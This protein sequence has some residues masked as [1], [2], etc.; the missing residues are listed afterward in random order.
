MKKIELK[1]PGGIL[2]VSFLRN[3]CLLLHSYNIENIYLGNRQ[4][5]ILYP[6]EENY[7]RLLLLLKKNN[8]LLQ[9]SEFNLMLDLN[10]FNEDN[11]LNLNSFE[12]LSKKFL[13]SKLPIQI[14]QK[15][16]EI[17]LLLS[18]INLISDENKNRFYIFINANEQ[19][20]L[21]KNS[22][23]L[24]EVIDFFYQHHFLNW[25]D[26]I[27]NFIKNN[28]NNLETF[29]N[30]QLLK[31]YITH[32]KQLDF[33]N[34]IFK[35]LNHYI[36][37]SSYT[38]NFST[39]ILEKLCIILKKYS[40]GYIFINPYHMLEIPTYP[41][42]NNNLLIQEIHKLFNNQNY[43][44]YHNEYPSFPNNII[45][46]NN[47]EESSKQLVNGLIHLKSIN[48]H[49][50]YIVLNIN[51]STQ[52][53]F[54]G[55][56]DIFIQKSIFRR[57]RR[58]DF[59]INPFIK[60]QIYK[61]LNQN[62]LIKTLNNFIEFIEHYDYLPNKEI[63]NLSI[64]II[65]KERIKQCIECFTVLSRDEQLCPICGSENYQEVLS[66]TEL[67]IKNSLYKNLL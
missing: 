24:N 51:E 60:P 25:E 23:T 55:M 9:D 41:I 15:I 67:I 36:I 46:L 58:Y 34:K 57:G 54:G 37:L 7:E 45:R 13:N 65:E 63:E 31:N 17:S 61:N 56:V 14:L 28:Y 47:F 19:S 66:P 3:L 16:D 33:H 29:S 64:K 18:P 22:F 12:E 2:S 6:K 4:N 39:T 40:I 52:K 48:N 62:Q 35:K 20:F 5:I 11:W 50:K 59:S 8:L 42:Y 30:F 49:N 44:I 10:I 43:I 32:N 38:Y 27:F 21:S 26:I 53:S 1:I